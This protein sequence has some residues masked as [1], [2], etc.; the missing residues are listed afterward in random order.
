[1]FADVPPVYNAPS[2]VVTRTS[3]TLNILLYNAIG[4]SGDELYGIEPASYYVKNLFLNMGVAWPLVLV[5]P[6]VY[7]VSFIVNP[8]AGST[9]QDG[10]I[11]GLV[12]HV[13]ALLWLAVLF[14]R[15][16]KVSGFLMHLFSKSRGSDEHALIV[17]GGAL[18]VPNLPSSGVHCRKHPGPRPAHNLHNIWRKTEDRN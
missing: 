12:L 13:Q 16:H 14:S 15:P 17:A 3:P 9:T 4:G 10:R 8:R 1:M 18:F 6:A 2:L 11:R 7:L 5:S